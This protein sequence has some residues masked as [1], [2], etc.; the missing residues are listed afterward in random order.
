MKLT[1]P[2]FAAVVLM[3]LFCTATAWAQRTVTGTVNDIDGIGLPGVNIIE[4]GTATGTVTDLDGSYS[5]RVSSDDAVLIFSYVGFGTQEIVVG[6]RSTIDV[7]LE[8]GT[9]LD[10]VVVVGYGTQSKEAVTGAVASVSGAEVSQVTAPNLAQSIQGRLPGVQVTQNGAPGEAP[11][12]QVRGIGSISFGSGPLVVVDGIPEAGSLNTF[13]GRNIESVTVLKDAASTSIYGSRAANGVLLIT[14]KGGG[15]NQGLQVN[16]ESTVGTQFTT[17]R[18]DLMNADQY[19]QF[20]DNLGA[21]VARDFNAPINSQTSQTY[22]ETDTDWQ[23]AMFQNGLLTQNT[24]SIS[25]GSENSRFFT[26]MGYLLDEGVFRGPEYQRYT[27]RLNSEHKIAKRLRFGQTLLVANDDRRLEPFLGGRTQIL[28]II[29]SLPYQPVFNPD[30]I[31]GFSGADQGQDSADPGNPVLASDLLQ[32][33]D[34]VFRLFGTLYAEYE[35]FDGLT[36][37]GTYGANFS[38]FRNFNRNPIYESTVNSDFNSISE[39]RSLSYSPL[40]SGQISYRKLIGDH[41]I[42]LT[43]VGE[44]QEFFNNFTFAN[45]NQTTND[46]SVISG[47]IDPNAGSGSSTRVIQSYLGRIN[48]GYK[49]KY[50]AQF[51]IRRDGSSVFAPGNGTEIFPSGAVAW[52]ISEEGF[53]ADSKISELKVRASYGRVGFSGLGPYSFQSPINNSFGPVFGSGNQPI[54]SF[55]NALANPELRWELTD[56]LNI[57]LDLGLFN[58]RLQFSAEYYDRQVDNLILNVQLPTSTGVSNTTDNI[59]SMSNTGVEFQL[60]YLSPRNRNFTWDISANV[61]ANTNEVSALSTGDEQIFSGANTET[62]AGFPVTVTQAGAPIGSFFG[63]QTDGLY[64]NDAEIRADY[65]D[66]TSD[67]LLALGIIPGATRWVD[68]NDDGTIDASDRVIIGNYLPD[69]T[70]GV[71]FNAEV[72]GFDFNIFL[73]GSQGNQ[74][75]NATRVLLTKFNRLFNGGVELL[76]AW[77]PSNTDTDQPVLQLSDPNQER[78]TSDRYVEDAS[79]LRLK[80]I[81]IGY[82]FPVSTGFLKNIRAYV[83]A[84]NL[85]TITD[86]TGYDPEIGLVQGGLLN[87]GIDFGQQPIAKSILFG[88][89]VGF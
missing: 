13:D 33:N 89:Q 75:Y 37:R 43:L 86:Y 45:A 83:S 74:V 64:Q 59:G 5:L 72:S 87:T 78:R 22:G 66:L 38:S 76:D 24:V 63:F 11:I 23:D 71:N 42:D 12:I 60:S 56:M 79:Y 15:Y 44:L 3:L 70:F 48:Y 21:N 39:S 26:S 88:V 69:F 31:G 9:T 35:L 8:E 25:G 16:L 80:N 52:R 82:T 53:M 10:Q 57:G 30:N 46:I 2:R 41:N 14:T 4:E 34:K 7:T 77:T 40:Y 32:S 1:F 18:L 58:N 20:A 47:G 65:P 81:T 61:S 50:I 29:Q 27:L 54:G 19:R 85:I 51:S 67:E 55:I 17:R 28:Q 68:Q 49:G 73:Q 62:T 6:S 84:Q 36:L